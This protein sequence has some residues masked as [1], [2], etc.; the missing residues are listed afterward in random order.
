MRENKI[1]KSGIVLEALG[2]GRFKIELEDS[3]EI[4]AYLSG[5]IRLHKIK[6]LPGDKVTVETNP[7]DEGK[8]RI[9]YRK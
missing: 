4:I 8:G 5:K 2:G 9:I 6:I 1:N 7:Y 3:N